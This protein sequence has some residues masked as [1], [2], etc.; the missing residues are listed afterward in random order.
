MNFKMKASDVLFTILC[1]L[2][3][4]S[5][6]LDQS[7]SV[8]FFYS[9]N[10]QLLNLQQA[11]D[12][13]MGKEQQKL[14]K[15]AIETLQQD[16]IEQ[17]RFKQ[18]LGTYTMAGDG[19]T[20]A[21]NSEI[22]FSSPLQKLSEEHIFPLAQKLAQGL[23]Q[24]SVAVFIP[25]PEQEVGCVKLKF[26]TNQHSIEKT[27]KSIKEKLPASFSQA[28]SLTLSPHLT[29]YN[30]TAVHSIAWIGNGLDLGSVKNAFPE[31]QIIYKQGTSW[32]IYK[33]GK[34]EKL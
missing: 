5:F 24:E 19:N 23:Q 26:A 9:N 4:C 6:A 31:D 22:F 20:T 16:H 8:A 18:I 34:K 14:E 1:F 33:N 29:D 13:L 21:D 32:L 3:S 25:S 17:G 12:R 30:Q 11:F 15:T 10:E 7:N 27:V 2:S 28:F